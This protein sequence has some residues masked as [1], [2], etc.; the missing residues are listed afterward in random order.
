M[1]FVLQITP[2]RRNFLWWESRFRPMPDFHGFKEMEFVEGYIAKSKKAIIL[3]LEK[4]ENEMHS[5]HNSIV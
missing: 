1:S 2:K 4:Y 5:L 3:M